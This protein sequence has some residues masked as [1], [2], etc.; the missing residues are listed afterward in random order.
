MRRVERGEEWRNL[1]LQPRSQKIKKTRP[2]TKM[3]GEQLGKG[4]S[5]GE[6]SLGW[7]TILP[8]RKTLHQVGTKGC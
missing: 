2:V 8:A 3:A 5:L 1:E 4:Y 7:E 6:R